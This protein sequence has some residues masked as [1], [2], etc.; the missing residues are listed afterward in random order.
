MPV[1]SICGFSTSNAQL[2]NLGKLGL[3][4]VEEAEYKATLLVAYQHAMTACMTSKI[5]PGMLPVYQQE[6]QALQTLPT[7][8]L[9]SLPARGPQ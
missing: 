3:T 8:E 6:V 2:R 1:P 7:S 4:E 9:Q 5:D